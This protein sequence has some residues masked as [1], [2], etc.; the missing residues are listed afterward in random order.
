MHTLREEL[1]E[2]KRDKLQVEQDLS[3]AERR[4]ES[5]CKK[6]GEYEDRSLNNTNLLNGMI[7]RRLLNIT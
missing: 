5:L 1:D 7:I 3:T 2:L 6:I 4:N